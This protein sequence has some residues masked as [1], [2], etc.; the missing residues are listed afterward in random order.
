MWVLL[1]VS[2]PG[3][4]VVGL[5]WKACGGVRWLG[6][7]TLLGPERT[8][9]PILCASLV[10]CGGC[11]GWC[12][13]FFVVRFACVAHGLW[14]VCVGCVLFENC[15]VDASI[16]VFCV[17]VFKSTWWMPWHQE[18]MK[19]VGICDKPRGVDNRTVIRGF[20][21]GETQHPSWGVTRA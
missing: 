2:T 21:N 6:V 7:D 12:G 14:V 11:G 18:P 5:G 17:Q 20:P 16:F 19:D 8:C 3:P 15:I 13:V 10:F 4:A 9:G 1:W